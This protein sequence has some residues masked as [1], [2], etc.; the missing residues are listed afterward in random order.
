MIGVQG[1]ID[2]TQ[3]VLAIIGGGAVTAVGAGLYKLG[4]T[5]GDLTRAVQGF[6]ERLQHV[7]DAVASCPGPTRPHR[8]AV[9]L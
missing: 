1:A 8:T 3:L 9:Q 6:D 5:I 2:T 7:E 4:A